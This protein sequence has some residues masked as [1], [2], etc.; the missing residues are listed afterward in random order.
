MYDCGYPIPANGHLDGYPTDTPTAVLPPVT[1]TFCDEVCEAPDIDATIFFFDGCNWK[2]IYVSYSI[3][4][5]LT[6]LV[7]VY[8]YF[9]RNP[10]KNKELIKLMQ[11]QTNESLGIS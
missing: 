6:I 2:V 1:C 7:Q 5:V 9:V 8:I 4:G 10:S 11:E 3:F